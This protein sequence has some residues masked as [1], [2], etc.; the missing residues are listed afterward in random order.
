MFSILVVGNDE[1]LLSTR[2]SVLASMKA[3][4]VKASPEDALSELIKHEF[5]LAV[6]CH[7]MQ[8]EESVRVAKVAHQVKHPARVIQVKGMTA[9][10]AGYA[11]IPAD[12][13]SD[14]DPELLIHKAKLLMNGYENRSS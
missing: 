9:S 2:A 1:V 10:R 13:F 14:T 8:V 6:L 12:A 4:V 11:D 3:N 7:T 5:D